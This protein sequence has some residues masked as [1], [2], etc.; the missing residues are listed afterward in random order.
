V[1]C[2]D[3]GTVAEGKSTCRKKVAFVRTEATSYQ[4]LL[5][6]W[7]FRASRVKTYSFRARCTQ[8]PKVNKTC[9][10]LQLVHLF[11]DQLSCRVSLN[12]V[13]LKAFPVV[14]SPT[15]S[16]QLTFIVHFIVKNAFLPHLAQSVQL[17]LMVKQIL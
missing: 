6:D 1:G 2:P 9:L 8:H 3:I 7:L 13:Y 14:L 4:G 15:L 17:W 16:L 5:L 11:L 12:E 10:H